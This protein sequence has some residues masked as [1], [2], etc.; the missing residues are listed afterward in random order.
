MAGRADPADIFVAADPDH[1]I[2]SPCGYSLEG[3]VAQAMAVLPMK[4][5]Q[6]WPGQLWV[7]LSRSSLFDAQALADAHP[8]VLITVSDHGIGMTQHPFI[9]G[10]AH[11]QGADR[12]RGA[13]QAV[14][15]GRHEVLEGAWNPNRMV[16]VRFATY[17]QAK[18]FYDSAKYLEARAAR[19][20]AGRGHFEEQ[21]VQHDLLAG[22]GAVVEMQ[23]RLRVGVRHDGR[24]DQFGVFL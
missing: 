6:A 21:I 8:G 19:A 7:G 18:A 5:K 23:Q 4:V 10:R 20:G 15:G 9:G 1:V 24:R 2:V 13:Q 3:A 12:R 11:G 14:R 17:D 22:G 16:V